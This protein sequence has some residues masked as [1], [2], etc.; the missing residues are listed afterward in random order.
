MGVSM[1]SLIEIIFYVTL[2]PAC[3][4]A[5]QRKTDRDENSRKCDICRP[6]NGF[7]GKRGKLENGHG[8]TRLDANMLQTNSQS[9]EM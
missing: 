7:H 3:S 2:R 4:N 9:F 1:L 6:C 8:E 5:K